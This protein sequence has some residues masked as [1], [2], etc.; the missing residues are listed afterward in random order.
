MD[1]KR[2]IFSNRDG[3]TLIEVLLSLVIT[4]IIVLNVASILQITTVNKKLKVTN[5]NHQIAAKQISQTLHTANYMHIG[6]DLQFKDEKEE[7]YT[8]SLDNS[9]VV[10]TPGYDIY[11]HD[12]DRLSFYQEDNKV[13]M[14]I[15]E[16]NQDSTYLI[17]T[18]YHQEEMKDDEEILSKSKG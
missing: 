1:R 17:G 6:N 5:S 8:I 14:Q 18:D 2:F 12:V 10:K 7:V 16:N 4:L 11:M 15:V 3:F 9:R 13:Y